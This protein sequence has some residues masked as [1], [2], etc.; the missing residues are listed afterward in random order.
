MGKMFCGWLRKAKGVDT[1]LLPTY[2]HRYA[3][4]RIVPAKLYPNSVLADFRRHF[5]E[6]WLPNLALEY[7]AERDATALPYLKKL[8]PAVTF[9]Q[10]VE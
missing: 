2:Q 7:F 8:L 4:G 6:E 3:D 5:N 1:S 9:K 10:L